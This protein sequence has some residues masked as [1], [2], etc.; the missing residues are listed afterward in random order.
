MESPTRFGKVLSSEI[1][2]R[3]FGSKLT[4]VRLAACFILISFSAQISALKVQEKSKRNF[5]RT[6]GI[7]SQERELFIINAF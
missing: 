6:Q 1:E 7:A 2:R 4:G 5:C 3:A